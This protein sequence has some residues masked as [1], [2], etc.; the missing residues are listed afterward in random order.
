MGCAPLIPALGEQ[1]Q[2]DLCEVKTNLTYIVSSTPGKTPQK[3]S[4][5]KTQTKTNQQTKL[6][7]NHSSSVV[8][9]TCD[10]GGDFWSPPLVF[11]IPLS[12]ILGSIGLNF[13]LHLKTQPGILLSLSLEEFKQ[14]KKRRSQNA[15]KTGV[16]EDWTPGSIA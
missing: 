11:F 13:L 5:S 12:P 9:H 14:M 15:T 4:V 10:P 16:S 3:D 2:V 6:K 1:V 8:V 7:K